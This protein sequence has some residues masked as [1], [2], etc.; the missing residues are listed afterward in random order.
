M[1]VIQINSE[2]NDCLSV[3]GI[4]FLSALVFLVN[5]PAYSLLIWKYENSG[6]SRKNFFPRRDLNRGP[7]APKANA[8]TTMLRCPPGKFKFCLQF[9]LNISIDQFNQLCSILKLD[10]EVEHFWHTKMVWDP[11]LYIKKTPT[12]QIIS[13]KSSHL[14]SSSDKLGFFHKLELVSSHSRCIK[15]P[16]WWMIHLKV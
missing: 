15:L 5:C 7:P 9:S 3:P 11:D 2:L 6:L 10:E 4:I 13:L 12:L 8:L 14:N 16:I 1:N